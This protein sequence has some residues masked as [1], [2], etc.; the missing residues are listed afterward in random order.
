MSNKKGKKSTII[1]LSLLLILVIVIM[2]CVFFLTKPALIADDYTDYPPEVKIN[3]N[4]KKYIPVKSNYKWDTGNK[5]V[6]NQ[7][8]E[9]NPYL[10]GTK[11]KMNELHGSHIKFDII[12]HNKITNQ[13]LSSKVWYNEE[14]YEQLEFSGSNTVYLPSKLNKPAVLV[15]ELIANEGSVQYLFYF[16][17]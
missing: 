16:Y 12:G 7:E 5:I 2:T 3:I 8:I 11:D 13:K 15:I 6:T 1:M 14:K 4:G 10:K 9:T 17:R